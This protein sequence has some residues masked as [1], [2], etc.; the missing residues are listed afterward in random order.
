MWIPINSTDYAVAREHLDTH[1]SSCSPMKNTWTPTIHYVSQSISEPLWWERQ[2]GIGGNESR[3][4]A[5]QIEGNQSCKMAAK[6]NDAV[7]DWEIELDLQGI[8][9]RDAADQV[10]CSRNQ[11]KAARAIATPLSH[12]LP[13]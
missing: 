3:Q 8:Y 13:N 6:P 2:S 7:S 12:R 9:S 11:A 5:K 4:K 10:N 1:Y